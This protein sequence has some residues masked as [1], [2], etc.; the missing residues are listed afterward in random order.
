MPIYVYEC[1]MCG[2]QQVSKPMAEINRDE[3]CQY[4][5]LPVERI[6]CVP[7]IHGTRD[8]FG[9]GTEFYDEATGQNIDTWG[10]WE[11]AGFSDPKHSS[12]LSSGLKARIK[13]KEEKI[14]KYDNHKRFSVQ[15]GGNNG[16]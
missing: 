7:A 4:C 8:S 10:K 12:H 6:V 16:T 2:E 11:K 14:K 13:R 1:E 9:I 3:V 15:T 5:G